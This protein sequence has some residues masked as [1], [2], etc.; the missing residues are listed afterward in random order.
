[1]QLASYK[2]QRGEVSTAMLILPTV[3]QQAILR[4]CL[5]HNTHT[6]IQTEIHT[7]TCTDHTHRHTT[8][9]IVLYLEF[10]GH[11]KGL[12]RVLQRFK[13]HVGVAIEPWELHRHSWQ[14]QSRKHQLI[15]V[16][17]NGID[18]VSVNMQHTQLN[19][20]TGAQKHRS[21]RQNQVEDHDGIH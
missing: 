7:Q 5:T 9:G 6:Q 13:G 4:V 20:N 8:S 18:Q 1:M 10:K 3:Q 14:T 21:A 15:T 12:V 16:F 11:L 19:S 17:Y 2:S